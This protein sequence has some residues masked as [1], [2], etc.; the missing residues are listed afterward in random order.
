MSE[1]AISYLLADQTGVMVTHDHTPGT[2]IR[3]AVVHEGVEKR[4]VLPNMLQ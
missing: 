4:K 1:I 2:D 3:F